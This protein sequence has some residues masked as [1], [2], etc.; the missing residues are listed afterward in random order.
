MNPL[1][2]LVIVLLIAGLLWAWRR[3]TRRA[4]L[5]NRARPESNESWGELRRHERL[6][7]TR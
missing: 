1:T 3:Q 7:V 5:R 2:P 6:H 4:A